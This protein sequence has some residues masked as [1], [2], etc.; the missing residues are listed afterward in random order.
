MALLLSGSGDTILPAMA[1]PPR[2]LQ[3]TNN[4][5]ADNDAPGLLIGMSSGGGGGGSGAFIISLN[6]LG[7]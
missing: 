6:F 7:R 1:N 3:S 5:A 4:K 2:P